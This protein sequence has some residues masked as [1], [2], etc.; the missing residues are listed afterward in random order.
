MLNIE[1]ASELD[2][3]TLVDNLIISHPFANDLLRIQISTCDDGELTVEVFNLMNK[4]EGVFVN[5]FLIGE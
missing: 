2:D 5:Q 4:G 3:E 1:F